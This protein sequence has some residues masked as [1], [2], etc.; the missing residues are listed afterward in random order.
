MWTMGL[1]ESK[2]WQAKWIGY[3][4]EPPETYQE[5][6]TSDELNLKGSEWIWFD[7][8]NPIKSAP[9]DT[10]FF[11]S[12]FEIASDKTDQVYFTAF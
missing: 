11:R 4:A 7:E 9:I 5:L 12:S 1:L 6:Q 10:R 8:G 2:D 3:D